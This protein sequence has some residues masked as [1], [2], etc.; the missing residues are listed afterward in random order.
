MESCLYCNAV[1][2]M[3]RSLIELVL[4]GEVGAR[5]HYATVLHLS[6]Y[7]SSYHDRKRALINPRRVP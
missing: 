7:S 2:R 1:V 3:G 5:G 4:V 6:S